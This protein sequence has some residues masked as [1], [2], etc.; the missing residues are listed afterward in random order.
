MREIFPS[1]NHQYIRKLSMIKKYTWL[2]YF[3]L[4][5][6]LPACKQ[7][8]AEI[9]GL[10]LEDIFEH[11]PLTIASVAKSYTEFK[12]RGEVGSMRQI[13]LDARQNFNLIFSLI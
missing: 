9:K 13:F 2:S 6:A 8:D 11:P 4:A 12:Y 7:K 10:K 1:M 3:F 5:L